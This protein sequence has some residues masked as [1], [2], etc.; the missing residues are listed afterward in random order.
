MP[1]EGRVAVEGLGNARKVVAALEA[2]VTE[3]LRLHVGGSLNPVA[4]G[5]HVEAKALRLTREYVVAVF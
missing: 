2:A 5:D 4:D 3:Y 1:A